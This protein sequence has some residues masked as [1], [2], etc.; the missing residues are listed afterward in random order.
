MTNK[1]LVKIFGQHS[2]LKWDHIA[3]M[4][5]LALAGIYTGT[6]GDQDVLLHVLTKGDFIKTLT[7]AF[8]CSASDEV[9]MGLKARLQS[10]INVQDTEGRTPLSHA[11][12]LGKK[13]IVELL[14]ERGAQTDSVCQRKR[15]A[16]HYAAAGGYTAIV[17][18]LLERGDV[19][20]DQQDNAT[21][22]PMLL[23]VVEDQVEIVRL[24]LPKTKVGVHS[25]AALVH[26][27]GPLPKRCSNR[28]PDNLDAHNVDVE[29]KCHIQGWV[30]LIFEWTYDRRVDSTERPRVQDWTPLLQ[31]WRRGSVELVAK[32]LQC[33]N[34][35]PNL[36]DEDGNHLLHHLSSMA[37]DIRYAELQQR[38]THMVIHSGKF[39]LT[40]N[41][42]NL[43]GETPIALA[44]I[45]GATQTF[46]VLLHHP[47]VDMT[48]KD[49]RG[50][51]PCFNAIGYGQWSIVKV[52]FENDK[53]DL[54]YT[55]LVGRNLLYLAVTSGEPK[56]VELLLANGRFDIDAKED[57]GDTV[58]MRA[59]RSGTV[60]I[61]KLLLNMKTLDERK[62]DCFLAFRLAVSE[63][64]TEVVRLLFDSLKAR[65]EIQYVYC[66]T[67]ATVAVD[68]G[69][70]ETL[71]FLLERCSLDLASKDRGFYECAFVA[72][73][74]GEV[75]MIEMI[76]R[77][78]L[79]DVEH[80]EENA[81]PLL[82]VAEGVLGKDRTNRQ[83]AIVLQKIRNYAAQRAEYVRQQESR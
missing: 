81:P 10:S 32:L 44:A 74:R 27:D 66:G 65:K 12:E 47:E 48:I 51:T 60:D 54:D 13:A 83:K 36:A 35:D 3:G 28:L 15:T 20:V 7:A 4:K 55:D 19:S 76:L 40:L 61:V 23:A 1:E 33:R 14:L 79:T 52:L 72:I 22:S 70:V 45:V 53:I 25:A 69:R 43:K 71:R 67:L 56:I 58:F 38:K 59:I 39:R 78:R 2:P 6:R 18:L 41:Q 62:E 68:E 34:I 73:Q 57:T 75:E 80:G 37:P 31:A 29:D 42:P 9:M 8:L 77:I 63:G 21:C 30:P 16:L 50:Y 46:E 11:A 64:H 5:L 17:R 82:S 24:L 26:H 49:N